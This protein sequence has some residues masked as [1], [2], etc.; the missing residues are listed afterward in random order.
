MQRFPELKTVTNVDIHRLVVHVSVSK[1]GNVRVSLKK[2]EARPCVILCGDCF[3]VQ[4][5][6]S[7]VEDLTE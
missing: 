6:F 4:G 7:S 3:A 1:D 5:D 2:S